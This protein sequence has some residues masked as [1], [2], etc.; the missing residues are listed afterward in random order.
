MNYMIEI[1][2][3][4]GPLDLL[5]HLIKQS[6]MDIFDI[7]IETITKQYL[8]YIEKMEELNLNIASEYLVMAAELIE[9]KS[10]TLLPKHKAETDDE[11]EEDPREQLI[12]RLLEY[13]K[14]KNVTSA[15]KECE[16]ERMKI[17]SSEPVNL[18]SLI[19]KDNI[20]EEFK[21]DDLINALNKMFERKELEKPLNTKVTTKEYS[22]TERSKQIK[23]ILK[24]KR[25]VN[26]IE[27]FDVFSK[28]YIV[29]TFLSVLN[30]ARNNDLKIV[31]D[32]NFGN[33]EIT[34]VGD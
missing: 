9:I 10:Y 8:E 7:N 32:K 13:E 21:V 28:D 16:L 34:S 27:L 1:N 33:I 4:E 18:S 5:L 26:F 6:E 11:Y 17:Y 23:N 29:V 3:F 12:S 31:Q 30:M 25:K 22:V 24:E 2:N 20:D 19:E 15:F 14:Y